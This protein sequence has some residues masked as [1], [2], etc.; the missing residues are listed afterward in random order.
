MSFCKPVKFIFLDKCDSTNNYLMREFECLKNDMPVM[1]SA[2][3]QTA[4]RGRFER[5]WESMKNLAI[6]MEKKP[7]PQPI[8]ITVS[9]ALM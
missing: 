5:K 7:G 1:V 4:G 8:S 3:E 6:S 2:E 9:P